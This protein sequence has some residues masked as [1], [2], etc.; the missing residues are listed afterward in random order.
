[1]LFRRSTP[2]PKV[3]TLIPIVARI[4]PV[5]RMLAGCRAT[6]ENASLIKWETQRANRWRKGN[7]G[8]LKLQAIR[9]DPQAIQAPQ[10]PL[11][12]RRA[13]APCSPRSLRTGATSYSD[14]I[15]CATQVRVWVTNRP[16]RLTK[17]STTSEGQANPMMRSINIVPPAV[18]LCIGTACGGGVGGGAGGGTSG[19]TEIGWTEVKPA[20]S[21]PSLTDSAMV[22]DSARGLVVL[23]GGSLGPSGG[24]RND[25]WEYDGVNWTR[26]SPTTSPPARARHAMAFDSFRSR[27]VL[28]GGWGG[29][30]LNDTWEWDGMDWKLINQPTSPPS[31]SEHAMAYD[32]ARL[33]IIM[34]GG[35][36]TGPQ[37]LSD[38]WELDGGGWLQRNSATSEK[39]W[40]AMAYDS[41]RGRCV[42]FGG[43]PWGPS[44]DTWEWDGMDWAQRT[45][46]TAPL[47]LV[48]HAMA[49]DSSRGR[50]VLFGGKDV[51]S[52]TVGDTWE[53]DGNDWTQLTP[54]TTPP[55]REKHAMAYD[56]IRGRVVMFGGRSGGFDG[57]PYLNDTWEYG[58]PSTLNAGGDSTHARDEEVPKTTRYLPDVGPN[59]ETI[60]LPMEG[61]A[62]GSESAT[63]QFTLESSFHP[64]G[65]GNK[66]MGLTADEALSSY[67]KS[68][69][70][71]GLDGARRDQ[72]DP[73]DW[74]GS[75]YCW[76]WPNSTGEVAILYAVGSPR[77]QDNNL[78][79]CS[80]NLPPDQF[81]YFINSPARGLVAF[82][83]GSQGSLCLGGPIGRHSTPLQV[84]R[85]GSSK[86]TLDLR[87]IPTADGLYA[88]A[89]GDTWHWQFWYR[90]FDPN[91]TSNF[92]HATSVTF[93]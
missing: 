57:G 33:R 5:N 93:Q 42:L 88:V 80:F 32:S 55:S 59:A 58:A 26:R 43:L 3:Y 86:L 85:I 62:R 73:G 68:K 90:D 10:L 34:F 87:R 54:S 4:L 13:M 9:W 66:S 52:N 35:L 29:S 6:D 61:L 30:P 23:F 53:W 81:G 19:G 1:V 63:R 51:N 74:V 11:L 49:F 18:V 24:L 47:D 22:F 60:P 37:Y 79:L 69:S 28:F 41:A 64:S 89:A 77:V 56:S 12:G 91:S 21:P 45:P 71:G 39:H 82:P 2:F 16:S 67:F 50:T 70:H 25:T 46:D 14:S 72:V 38:T 27:T 65:S 36:R 48:W 78:T 83:G 76:A 44:P 15:S 17:S 75:S 40:H 31:R 7:H 92:T 20:Q 8:P 84:T